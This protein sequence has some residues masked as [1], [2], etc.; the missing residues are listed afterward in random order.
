MP[1][2]KREAMAPVLCFLGQWGRLG[3]RPLSSQVWVLTIHLC[4]L[5][6]ILVCPSIPSFTCQPT[7]PLS[8]CTVMHPSILPF[9]NIP[10]V[11][12]S[13]QILT[14]LP[15]HPSIHIYPAIRLSMFIEH[16]LCSGSCSRA[17][18]T[19]KTFPNPTGWGGDRSTQHR[20]PPHLILPKAYS[21]DS[22]NAICLGRGEHTTRESE[23]WVQIL[24]PP[25][26]SYGT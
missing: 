4:I 19:T 18:L 10:F 8:I 26:T 3:R 6:S 11:H 24:S 1:P 21:G 16:L 25:P 2:L 17:L 9:S 22:H 23:A 7:H 5:L 20:V 14:H 13:I 12:L 15:I